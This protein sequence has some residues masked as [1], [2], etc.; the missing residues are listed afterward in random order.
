[1][2]ENS[3]YSRIFEIRDNPVQERQGQNNRC[4]NR[5]PSIARISKYVLKVYY[6]PG[7]NTPETYLIYLNELGIGINDWFNV[8]ISV[9]KKAEDK[10][11]VHNREG[12]SLLKTD[13]ENANM[14]H[15]DGGAAEQSENYEFEIKLSW[16][17]VT[18][19]DI[20]Y[21][22]QNAKMTKNADLYM[23]KRPNVQVR[24]FESTGMEFI[25]ENH[26]FW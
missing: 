9:S 22:F 14:K 4:L 6:C 15:N 12:L 19:F 23:Y 20:T 21:K 7:T 13:D 5:N 25:A 10:K 17:N 26:S 11:P 18:V 16:Q 1:M 2:V 3:D 8:V 24:N